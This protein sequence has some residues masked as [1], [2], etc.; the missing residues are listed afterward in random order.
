M[1]MAL[2][3]EEVLEKALEMAWRLSEMSQPAIRGTKRAINGWLR[4]AM[5]LYE[6]SAALEMADFFGPDVHAAREAFRAKRPV[7]FPSAG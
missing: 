5:P 7:K 2:P 4:Q 1:T 6:H 3:T